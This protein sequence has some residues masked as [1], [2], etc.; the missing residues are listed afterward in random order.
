MGGVASHPPFTYLFVQ[1]TMGI[2]L[3]LLA[4]H[5]PPCFSI[6]KYRYIATPTEYFCMDQCLQYYAKL[7]Y[8]NH[9]ALISSPAVRGFV[10]MHVYCGPLTLKFEIQGMHAHA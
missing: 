9:V 1:D 6:I 10:A 7:H 8:T 4:S 5:P 2:G 3:S